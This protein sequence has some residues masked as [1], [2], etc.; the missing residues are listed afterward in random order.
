[1]S[2][3]ESEANFTSCFHVGV[4]MGKIYRDDI[5]AGAYVGKESGL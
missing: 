2:D 1:M 3:K 5:M 4:A